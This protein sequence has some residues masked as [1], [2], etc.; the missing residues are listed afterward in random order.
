MTHFRLELLG[1]AFAAVAMHL[2]EDARQAARNLSIIEEFVREEEMS[3]EWIADTYCDVRLY[4]SDLGEFN[5]AHGVAFDALVPHVQKVR[6]YAAVNTS[7]LKLR[8]AAADVLESALGVL[9]GPLTWARLPTA[10]SFL[11]CHLKK[12]TRAAFVRVRDAEARRDDYL[13]QQ[14]VL[15][16][17][18]L[19]V[20]IAGRAAILQLRR[21]PGY[22]DLPQ[23]GGPPSQRLPAPPLP[24]P[25]PAGARCPAGAK[26]KRSS[27]LSDRGFRV[28]SSGPPGP[29]NLYHA[30]FGRLRQAA[31]QLVEFG[32]VAR[33]LGVELDQAESDRQ[34]AHLS[35][36]AHSDFYSDLAAHCDSF[37]DSGPPGEPA[38]AGMR[39]GL[40][41]AM[42]QNQ[43][44]LVHVAGQIWSDNLSLCVQALRSPITSGALMTAVGNWVSALDDQIGFDLCDRGQAKVQ[45]DAVQLR[46]AQAVSDSAAAR[47]AVLA[48]KVLTRER[49]AALQPAE[50]LPA[51]RLPARPAKSSPARPRFGRFRH[52]RPNSQARAFRPEPE[53]GE[54]L[55]GALGGQPPA[56]RR[57][58]VAGRADLTAIAFGIWSPH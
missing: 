9:A 11:L 4:V 15:A 54:A 37:D 29:A 55:S 43:P 14:D 7:L 3:L 36:A 38:P 33:E 6:F 32:R 24:A 46:L 25:L 40:I 19:A 13:C 57:L 22:V 53:R 12:E 44:A 39:K 2:R 27:L 16:S 50:Q 1:R 20:S 34:E 17:E 47:F 8:P 10:L 45:R 31:V 58:D 5:A 18:A 51:E 56:A 48:L 23:V 41:A 30:V 35:Y 21:A 52:S 49:L 42:R 26:A 28:A